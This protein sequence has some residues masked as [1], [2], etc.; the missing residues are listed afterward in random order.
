MRYAG[1]YF[2]S[3]SSRTI[4]YK[5]MLLA[6]QVD[7]LFHPSAAG[8]DQLATRFGFREARFTPE[9][10]RLNGQPLKLMGLNRHQSFPYSGYAQGKRSQRRDA[11]IL[12]HD[13]G[14][15]LPGDYPQTMLAAYP[16]LTGLVRTA[17]LP[18]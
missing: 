16:E 11:E 5:G 6:E 1:V 3:L 18:L 17:G 7:V 4:V 8:E 14:Q 10:F 15:I 13:L 12:K 9:G 2:A